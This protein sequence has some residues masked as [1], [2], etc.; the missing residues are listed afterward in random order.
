MD[1]TQK[2]IARGNR[3]AEIMADDLMIEA[4][5]HIEAELYRLFCSA[6]PTDTEALAQIK[7]MQYMHQKY[8]AFL[9]NALNDGK[10][11]TMELEKQSKLDKLKRKFF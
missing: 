8:W 3:A 2:S 1:K 7:S 10:M 11:A 6:Q 9:K 5:Q 4:K